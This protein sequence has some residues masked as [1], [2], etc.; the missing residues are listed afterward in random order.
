[1]KRCLAALALLEMLEEE[2]D[3]VTKRG[4]TRHWI[5]RRGDMIVLAKY[6]PQHGL[7]SSSSTSLPISA[8]HHLLDFTVFGFSTAAMPFLFLFAERSLVLSSESD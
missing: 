3:R 5:K 2:G 7:C 8:S 1:V 4:K 6:I